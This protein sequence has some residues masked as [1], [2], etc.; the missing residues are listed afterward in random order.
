MKIVKKV[1][2]AGAVREVEV[3][4]QWESGERPKVRSANVAETPERKKRRNYMNALR[5]LC[6]L[7][8]MNFRRKDRFATLTFGKNV[9]IDEAKR[10]LDKFLRAMRKIFRLLGRDD[11]K[12]IVVTEDKHGK[13]RIHHHII[14]PAIDAAIV[15]DVWGDNGHVIQ[16]TLFGKDFTGLAHYISKEPAES[17]KR[18]WRQ[19]KNLIH[20]QPEY[21]PVTAEDKTTAPIRAPRGYRRVYSK[22]EWYEET[23]LW[24][25]AKFVREGEVDL[26]T[27]ARN[28]EADD[29]DKGDGT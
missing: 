24:K 27:G 15:E 1:T 12:Y 18:R 19:S 4:T 11:F 8:N 20:P 14:M 23:G 28:I 26:G 25:Y 5:K 7:V 9:T 17:N 6:R 2:D 10:L 21:R 16:S 3:T 13:G 22:V 29:E